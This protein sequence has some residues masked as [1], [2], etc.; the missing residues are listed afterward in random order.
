M[1]SE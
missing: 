1:E